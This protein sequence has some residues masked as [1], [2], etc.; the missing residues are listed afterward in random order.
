MKPDDGRLAQW[1][2][3][4]VR[5][6]VP[7]RHWAMSVLLLT[8][9]FYLLSWSIHPLA[10]AYW[11]AVLSRSVEYMDPALKLEVIDYHGDWVHTSLLSVNVAPHEPG[12]LLLALTSCV[13]IA[14]GCASFARK[15][16]WL[17]FAYLLRIGCATQFL[18]CLYFWLAPGSFP[19]SPRLHLRD[20]FALLLGAIATTPA[21]MAL[22]YYPLDFSLAQKALAT[23]IVLGYLIGAAPFIMLLHVIVIHHGSLLFMP[24]CYFVLGVPLTI[25]LVVTLYAYCASWPGALSIR[26]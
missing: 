7:A 15:E 4:A 14:G 5:T 16:R 22:L 21:L 20:I 19:Y 17:P 2:D 9:L 10:M 13:C 8:P 6:N 12:I 1:Q 3:R 25:G 11:I 24:F 26:H 23:T 18:A